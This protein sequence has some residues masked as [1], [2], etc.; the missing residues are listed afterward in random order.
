MF[1]KLDFSDLIE[2]HFNQVH[3]IGLR[4]LFQVNGDQSVV[5]GILVGVKDSLGPLV[6]HI[7]V[8]GVKLRDDLCQGELALD[9]FLAGG[10]LLQVSEVEQ[11]V[12]AVLGGQHKEIPGRKHFELC[13]FKLLDSPATVADD[14]ADH[15]LGMFGEFNTKHILLLRCSHP[16]RRILLTGHTLDEGTKLHLW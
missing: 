14:A 13:K 3:P 10:L 15:P 7:V 16:K 12:L 1:V 9:S 6:G 2:T 11:V 4:G 5:L 8:V